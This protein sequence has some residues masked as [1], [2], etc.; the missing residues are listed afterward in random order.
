MMFCEMGSILKG[1]YDKIL[2]IFI[3]GLVGHGAGVSIRMSLYVT[4]IMMFWSSR[5]SPGALRSRI[6]M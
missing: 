4:L 5:L 1:G 3:L 2:L 6:S